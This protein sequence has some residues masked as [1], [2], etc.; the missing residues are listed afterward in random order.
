MIALGDIFGG[1]GSPLSLSICLSLSL[2]FSL[3][4]KL[5]FKNNYSSVEKWVLF[6]P[7]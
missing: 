2:S 1:G 3:L 6:P 5:K 4:K 7:S